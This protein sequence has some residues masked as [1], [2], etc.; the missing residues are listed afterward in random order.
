MFSLSSLR[1][2]VSM[3]RSVKP[4]RYRYDV[5]KATPDERVCSSRSVASVGFHCQHTNEAFVCWFMC[6][7]HLQDKWQDCRRWEL[8]IATELPEL[9]QNPRLGGE[10]TSVGFGGRGRG[11]R[12][13]F[14]GGGFRGNGGRGGRGRGGGG[15]RGSQKRSYSQAFDYWSQWTVMFLYFYCC[16]SLRP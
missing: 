16:Y 5:C 7:W 3:C 11:G 4:R 1:V 13:S 14:G 6:F 10:R 12:R 8:T 9:E 2:C 15:G